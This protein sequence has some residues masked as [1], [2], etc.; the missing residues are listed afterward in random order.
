MREEPRHQDAVAEL[1]EPRL[2]L[3]AVRELQRELR[4][5]AARREGKREAATEAGIH[6]S[7]LM[8]A[9]GLTEALNVRR[10]PDRQRFRDCA[11]VLDQVPVL[12]RH[13]LDRLAAFRLDH[14]SRDRVQAPA[15]EVAE[16]V[17]RELVAA[18]A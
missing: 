18:A 14:R 7:D 11:A 10:A 3:L 17:D 4:I 6:V 15:L 8:A 9:V 5:G 2:G 16:D 12:D 13:A 1:T